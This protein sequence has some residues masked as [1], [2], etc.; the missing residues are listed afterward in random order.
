MIKKKVCMIGAYAVG[1]TS[2]VRRYVS[3]I[4]DDAYHTTVGVKVDQRGE[5]VDGE[6]VRMMIW[7]I[8]GKDQFQAIQKSYLQGSAGF[9]YVIDGTRRETLDAVLEEMADIAELHPAVDSVLLAVNK[10]DLVDEW[11]LDEASLAPVREK[12]I[13]V[14]FTSA[15]E[16][17][18]VE[19]A[20][21]ELAGMMVRSG[22]E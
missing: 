5:V 14:L 2:L 1:K 18:N 3:D 21:A 11:E 12:G 19:K 13:P 4:Y 8:A 16:G 6:E 9:L 10:H 17:E 15:K 7:D 22:E 20:F